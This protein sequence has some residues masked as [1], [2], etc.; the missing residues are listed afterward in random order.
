MTEQRIVFTGANLVDGEH[1]ARPGMSVVVEGER[2][3]SVGEAPVEAR[4]GDRV[5]RLDGRTL[6][7]GMVQAHFHSHFGAFGEGVTAPALGLEAAPPYLSML[8]AANARTALH[9]GFTGALG[10]SSAH[11]IDVCL[12]EAILLGIVEGPRYRAWHARAGYDRRVPPTSPTT[13]PGSWSSAT[14]GSPTRSTART[15]GATP[16]APSSAGAPTSSRSP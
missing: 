13:A 7:P 5:V 16:R 3:A 4:P 1:P 9:C 12:K 11:G 6:M 15:P 8:A 10:S 14:R 2:I